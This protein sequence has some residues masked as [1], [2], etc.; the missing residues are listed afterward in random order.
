M[1]S[2]FRKNVQEFI[3]FCFIPM[4]DYVNGQEIKRNLLVP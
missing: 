4:K 1:W 3:F 2:R